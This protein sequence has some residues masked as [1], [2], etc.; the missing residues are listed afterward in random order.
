M[1]VLFFA[2]FFFWCLSFL[3]PRKTIIVYYWFLVFRRIG[4]YIFLKL[5]SLFCQPHQQLLAHSDESARL[6]VQCLTSALIIHRLWWRFNGYC[7]SDGWITS[8]MRVRTSNASHRR[9]NPTR[10]Q[11]H[12]TLKPRRRF[13]PLEFVSAQF[14]LPG[15]T[16]SARSDSRRIADLARLISLCSFRNVRS[17]E[18]YKQAQFSYHCLKQWVGLC[19]LMSSDVSWHIRDKLRPMPKHGSI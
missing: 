3:H 18:V 1:S 19:R 6:A 17:P 12:D 2:S 16:I 4:E 15:Y 7:C 10:W 5:F 14:R 9:M 11:W 13:K 8:V